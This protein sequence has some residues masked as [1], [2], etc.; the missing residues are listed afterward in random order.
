MKKYLTFFTF[1]LIAFIMFQFTSKPKD[2]GSS[3]DSQ[4][5]LSAGQTLYPNKNYAV[6]STSASDYEPSHN[7]RVP[8][9]YKEVIPTLSPNVPVQ[10]RPH[11][12]LVL[13]D[14]EDRTFFDY[15]AWQTFVGLVWPVDAQARGVADQ[16]VTSAD[17]KKYN[18]TDSAKSN[19]VPVVW[20]SFRTFDVVLPNNETALTVQPPSWDALAYER[21]FNLD[22][23]S[24]GHNPNALNEAFSAPLIDQNR[25]YVR[26]NLQLNEVMYEFIR[27]NKWYLKENLPKS[28]TQ[29]T[30]PPLPVL[31]D[32]PLHKNAQIDSVQ[33]PQTKTVIRQPINGNSIEIKSSW[34]IMITEEDASKPWRIVDDL[35]RYF[36]S[37]ANMTDAVTGDTI[38]DQ[39]VGLVGLHI[40]VKTPQF[41]QGIWSSFEHVDNVKAPEGIRPSFND[42]NG[43]FHPQGFDSMPLPFSS[44]VKAP[45]EE[46]RKPVEVSRIYKI[47]TTPIDTVPNLPYGLSTV[48]LNK[49]YQELFEGTVWENYQLV[50]TQWPTDPT[51]FYAKPFLFPRG[52]PDSS[53][54]QPVLDAYAR[55]QENAVSAYPRWAGLPI[56]QTG[57]LNTTMET[58]FQNPSAKPQMP[59][60]NS[61]CMGCHYGASDTDFSWGLK[62]RTYPQP[63]DQGRINPVDSKLLEKPANTSE[64]N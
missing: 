61:S 64:E 10:L 37:T 29:A 26:Y 13:T 31:P 19:R 46:E 58:Y 27:Q 11:S 20:E 40:V 45:L 24:K 47:P 16:S 33:Q 9:P 55:A 52:T 60:E 39:K 23:T 59:L 43:V 50:I 53:Q 42:G 7:T 1:L 30:L 6:T 35:S 56:P 8:E 38:R 4:T 34:R 41:T 28:P 36:V 14:V 12:R 57:A 2:I 3:Y 18:T 49:S 5:P 62:L 44:T 21:P 48:G 22:L 25:Q 51:T 15:F 17:F 54:P 63:Y 32:S